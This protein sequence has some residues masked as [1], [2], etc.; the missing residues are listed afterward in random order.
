TERVHSRHIPREDLA[1]VLREQ[2]TSYGCGPRTL[3]QID[4]IVRDQACAVVTGQQVGLFSGPLYT[5]YKA[6]T[7]IK[8]SDHLNRSGLGSFVPVFWLASDDHD[9]AEIDHIVLLDQENRLKEVRCPMPSFE[10]KMPASNLILPPDVLDCI[11]QLDDLT[12]DSEFKEEIIGRLREAYK[13]GRSFA[14]AFARW[15]TR[16]FESYGLIVIDPSHPRLKEMGRD[17][18]YQEIAS[19]SPS[20][21]RAMATSQRLRQAG[22]SPQIPL[23]EGILNIFYLDRER[24]TIQCKDGTFGIKGRPPLTQTKELLAWAREKPFLF[25]PN[26][27]LRPIYQDALLPTAAYVGGH[28][29]IAYFAQMKGVYE[30]FHLPMPVIYPRKSLT[31]VEKK[32]EHILKKYDLKIPDL[33]SHAAGTIAEITKKQIPDSLD[34]ALRLVLDHLEQDFNGLKREIVTFEPTLKDS[35]NLAKGKMN[36]QLKF[37]EKKILQAAAKRN[38]TALQ[39]LH[40]AIDNLFPKQKLQER[41]FNIVPFL[42]KYGSTFMEKLDQA[43]DID[44]HNHRILLI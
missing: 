24:R 15:M 10:G 38:K 8:L 33:W 3:G 1:A 5:V 29:E 39:Q 14:E 4:K 35:V 43:I 9:L 36:Q 12:Y 23:H 27:L 17:V 31:I 16:L 18:F 6:L 32:V 26:V 21:Q 13:P 40:K 34:R 20:T 37:M 25:S 11:Q 41:V 28:A 44:E 42:I 30:A 19:E 7:A 2:N 22:Y